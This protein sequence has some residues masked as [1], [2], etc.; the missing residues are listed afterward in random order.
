MSS[1]CRAVR[2][3][4]VVAFA[5]LL[6]ACDIDLYTNLGEREANAMVAVLLRDGI[7]ASRKVQDNGQLTVVVD[8]KRFAEAMAR[9]DD[10]GLPGQSFS[11]MGAV[12]KGNGLVSSPV[13][14]RAQMVYAL[15]EE[16]SNSV[17]QIDGIIAARVHVVLPD[18]DLL[19][20]VISP[21]S[22][23]VLV[24]YDPGTDINQLIPQIKTLVANGISGLSYEGVS[25]TAIKAAVARNGVN[26][27]PRL[28]SFMG[29][30]ML[31]D[32]VPRARLMFGALLLIGLALAGVLGWQHWQRRR[33]QA[34][35][36][37]EDVA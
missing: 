24:R 35:Y 25:V 19:K 31:E 16:L 22:A 18:N 6:Q 33:S 13:Q 4:I 20:R 30:W 27:Q 12:F 9:L 37:V 23:S 15:S 8:E 36:V 28:A 2:L 17:S 11:N 32:N 7:P 10:A 34:L 21:S 26:A 29:L 3:M 5:G 1:R 14:E